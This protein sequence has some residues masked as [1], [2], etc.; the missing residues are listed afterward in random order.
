MLSAFQRSYAMSMDYIVV[1]DRI[2]RYPKAVWSQDES[3]RDKNADGTYANRGKAAFV[4][5]EVSLDYVG[6][7]K[8]IDVPKHWDRCSELRSDLVAQ[9]AT[10][11][12]DRKSALCDLLTAHL[13]TSR[14]E[15]L[16]SLH[17]A[18]IEEKQLFVGQKVPKAKGERLEVSVE[19]VEG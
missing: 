12:T 9:D 7:R 13:Q 10:E 19:D 17:A 4:T 3:K 14:K 1:K 8:P 16:G 2:V 15:I 5:K 18:G 6:A 11:E